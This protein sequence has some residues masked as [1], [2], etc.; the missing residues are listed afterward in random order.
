M[1]HARHAAGRGESIAAREAQPG[2]GYASGSLAGT[3]E[4]AIF[5][6]YDDALLLALGAYSMS[7]RTTLPNFRAVPARVVSLAPPAAALVAFKP[8]PTIRCRTPTVFDAALGRRSAKFTIVRPVPNICKRSSL[9]KSNA[10]R[11]LLP[12][13][14]IWA[15]AKP[16]NPNHPYLVRKNVP[17]FCIRQRYSAL[18][19]PVFD[20]AGKRNVQRIY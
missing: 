6:S 16:A 3:L 19:I 7:A 2:T 9:N 17:V 10:T 12:A 15:Q 13:Q 20:M 4:I 8:I 18:L 14:A 11:Q 5:P 1:A